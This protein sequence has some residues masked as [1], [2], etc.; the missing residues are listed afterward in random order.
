MKS[1]NEATDLSSKK[2]DYV[3]TA[4]KAALGAVPFV[5]SLLAEVAGN[6]IPN[7]RVDR[8][9]KFAEAL[10]NRIAALEE[11]FVKSQITN[12]NFTDLIEE[13]IRQAAR[14]LSDERR[15]YISSIIANSLTSKDIEFVESKHLMRILGEIND[16][17][18][19]WL[20]F[21]LVPTMGG[22]EEF[23]TR[24]KSIITPVL[25]FMGSPPRF[26]TRHHS[27]R[28]I[29]NIW[30]ASVCCLQHIEQI[31][32]RSSLNMITKGA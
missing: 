8:I 7:Q 30:H 20:R 26:T 12:E 2:S 21:F 29:R 3:A 32:K 19:V 11:E 22:D 24:H 14:S 4:A 6:V 13:G 9:V 1:Q 27:N 18:I 17:E 10:Q 31:L 16:I 23:R 25:D 5:G 28:V 15:E